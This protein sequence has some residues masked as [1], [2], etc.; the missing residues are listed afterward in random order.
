[1]KKTYRP[2]TLLELI[3]A[4]AIFAVLMGV[5]MKFFHEAQMAWTTST[6]RSLVYDNARIAMDLITRDLQAAYYKKDV[7]PF[8]QKGVTGAGW[9]AY[10]NDLLAFVS[11][12]PIPQEHSTTP[13]NEVIYQLY[14][15]SSSTDPNAGW[16]M[17]SVT[18]NKTDATTVNSKYNYQGNF[19]VSANTATDAF[20]VGGTSNE[21]FV[22]VIPNVTNLT[23]T[24][25]RKDGTTISPA[26]AG[27]TDF[28]YIVKVELT[29]LDNNSWK[30]W[31]A[32]GATPNQGSE[33]SDTAA[34]REL[35][36]GRERTFTKFIFLG[37]R[38]QSL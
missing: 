13:Y 29:L 28:P 10:R 30:R 34:A 12:T 19:N 11:A 15:A 26:P 5:M 36:L 21:D 17:R 22:K 1:M 25:F 4:M 14:Y 16:L 31:L 38:G 35:R 2:F 27:P 8:W 32:Y 37:E 9:G 24:C 23:F 20:T 7:T 18:G 3:T 33:D 6:Q